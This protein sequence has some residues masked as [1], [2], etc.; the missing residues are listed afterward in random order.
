VPSGSYYLVKAD[1]DHTQ[2]FFDAVF[3]FSLLFFHGYA[4]IESFYNVVHVAI[5]LLQVMCTIFFLALF[6][7]ASDRQLEI[8]TLMPT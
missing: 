5:T 3:N 1:E 2:G 8:M 4:P 6:F 7:H